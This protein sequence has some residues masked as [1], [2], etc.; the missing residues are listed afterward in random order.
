MQLKPLNTVENVETNKNKNIFLLVV[1]TLA[2]IGNKLLNFDP[3]QTEIYFLEYTIDDLIEIIETN[4]FK[5]NDMMYLFYCFVSQTVNSH[6][7][8]LSRLKEKIRKRDVFY[9]AL[10]KLLVYENDSNSADLDNDLYNFYFQSAA[11][12]LFSTS[13]ITRTK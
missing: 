9:Y 6:L 3:M 7:R 11:Y 8:V 12:G 13:P 5:R 2:I 10:S 1:E 4:V